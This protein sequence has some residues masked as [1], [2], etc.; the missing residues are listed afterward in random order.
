MVL[1]LVA[2]AGPAAADPTNYQRYIIGERA[3]GMGGAQTAAVNDPMATL[4]NPAGL[5]FVTSSMVSASMGIYSLDYRKVE[6]GFVPSNSSASYYQSVDA[7][8]LE[9]QNDLSLPSTL[10]LV[11][12]FG[13]RLSQ[14]GPRR[15]AVGIA[16]LVP[17]QDS[18]TLKARWE[19][20]DDPLLR[21]RETYRLTEVYKQVWTGLSYALRVNEQLGLG[22]AVFLTNHA[23]TRSLSQSRFGDIAAAQ[24]QVEHCGLLQFWDSTI[25]IDVVSLLFRVGALWQPHEN[26]RL[27]LAASAPSIKLD[28]LVLWKTAGKLDQ[29]LGYADVRGNAD[30]HIVYYTDAYDLEVASYEPASFRGGVA[31]TWDE[32][33]VAALDASFHLPISYTRIRGDPVEDRRCPEGRENCD[34]PNEEASPKWFDPGIVSR[35]TRRP[36]VN[37]NAGWELIVEDTWTIRNGLFTDFSSA[38]HV[39]AGLEPQLPRVHRYGATLSLGWQSRGYDIAVGAMGAFGRGY[40]SVNHPGSELQPWQPASMEERALYVFISGIQKAVVRG[41]KQVYKKVEERRS[42]ESEEGG[43][44]D[45]DIAEAPEPDPP[46][47]ETEGEGP[48]VGEGE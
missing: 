27:G 32:R 45:A 3:L 11:R 18:F 47:E 28:N 44:E 38:P 24:C 9:Y 7:E 14:G 35:V 8:N 12:P 15:H 36:V 6:G 2:V 5:V 48:P 40:A 23:Y 37:F 41:A 20:D 16:V 42:V 1:V 21:D 46:P 26:W 22:I 43:G 29:T 13:K 34:E 25:D 19:S 33:F 31:F 4:Y 17:Y 30:D 39:V 10:A